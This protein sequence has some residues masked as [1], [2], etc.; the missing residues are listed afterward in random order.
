M[1]VFNMI[2]NIIQVF[3]SLNNNL[4]FVLIHLII[5]TKNPATR[6]GFISLALLTGLTSFHFV[7][8]SLIAFS[9][10]RTPVRLVFLVKPASRWFKPVQPFQHKKSYRMGRIFLSWSD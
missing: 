4:F 6:V 3:S 1:K 8:A 5:N 2:L 9:D 7:A 10:R